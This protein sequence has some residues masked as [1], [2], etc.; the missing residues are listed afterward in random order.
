MHPGKQAL[1]ARQPRCERRRQHLSDPYA[2]GDV[3]VGGQH[4]A[5]VAGLAPWKPRSNPGYRERVKKSG[6]RLFRGGALQ[7]HSPYSFQGLGKDG[8]KIL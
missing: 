7:P 5:L 4:I 3:I 6:A 8:L 1:Q 2:S